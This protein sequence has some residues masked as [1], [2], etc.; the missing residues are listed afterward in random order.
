MCSCVSGIQILRIN[1]NVQS[2]GMCT[3]LPRIVQFYVLGMFSHPLQ[4]SPRSNKSR[5]VITPDLFPVHDA[6]VHTQVVDHAYCRADQRQV[7]LRHPPS[8]C[9]ETHKSDHA[10]LLGLSRT[11]VK[12]YVY[13]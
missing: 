11:C 9:I 13:L 7:A 8:T 3:R 2:L 6:L 12:Q 5:P 1:P 4:D 10:K